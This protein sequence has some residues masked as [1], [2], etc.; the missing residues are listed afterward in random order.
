[1]AFRSS[2]RTGTPAAYLVVGLGNPGEEYAGTRHN[3]GEE[4]V[5]LL[6]GRLGETLRPGKDRA[7]VA[8]CRL[9]EHRVVLAFPD[10]LVWPRHNG[11]PIMEMI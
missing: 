8:E 7:A 9:G 2:E 1:M 4:A 6:A 10:F 5:N 3:V 11:L